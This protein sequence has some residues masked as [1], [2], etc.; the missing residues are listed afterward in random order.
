MEE[1]KSRRWMK[2]RINEYVIVYPSY[3]PICQENGNGSSP[4][5]TDEVAILPGC[6]GSSSDHNSTVK[7][8]W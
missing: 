1:D 7:A 5:S 6:A 8:S 3:F 4:F 2:E